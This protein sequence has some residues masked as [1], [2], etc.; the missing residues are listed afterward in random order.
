MIVEKIH[1]YLNEKGDTL[2]D[3]I[4]KLNDT[5]LKEV[6]ENSEYVFKRQFMQDSQFSG[7]LRLSS[8]G[9]CPRKLAYKMFGFSEQ[10]KSI[11]ARA[12]IIFWFGDMIEIGIVGLAKLAGVKLEDT[13]LEQRTVSI[14]LDGNK[15]TGHPD[16]IIGDCLLE[17]KS[18]SSFAYKEF[19]KGSI[20]DSYIAQVNLYM[21][22]LGLDKCCFVAMDKNSSALGELIIKKDLRIVEE[23]KRNLSL[24]LNSTKENLPP[25]RYE[26]NDKGFYPWQCMY[27]SYWKHC[28]KTADKVLVGK[29][30]KLKEV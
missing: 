16:G 29:R 27:C 3:A 6:R 21:D 12:K 15:I 1:E 10:G 19:D 28:H 25:A 8:A 11:D 5:I 26:C 20:N 18:M 14:E 4:L 30:Y 24:V 7:N 22:A 23:V 17:I 13:G 9:K 2:N